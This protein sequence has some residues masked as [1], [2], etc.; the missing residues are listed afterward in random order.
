MSDLNISAFRI[1]SK[2][3]SNQKMP[4]NGGNI[5]EYMNS[6]EKNKDLNKKIEADKEKGTS[7]TTYT[8][9]NG[10]FVGSIFRNDKNTSVQMK[11]GDRIKTYVDLVIVKKYT[12]FGVYFLMLINFIF[13]SFFVNHFH[14]FFVIFFCKFYCFFS[15]SFLSVQF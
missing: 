4:Q 6:L 13:W 8:D 1:H 3:I 5:E 7:T 9:K 12:T 14:I 10:K 11:D 15:G 2:P